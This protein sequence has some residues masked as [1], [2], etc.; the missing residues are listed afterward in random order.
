MNI[1]FLTTILPS[2]R[3]HGSDVASQNIVDALNQNG[4]KV[5]VVGYSRKEDDLVKF[6]PQEILV[7]QRYVETASS[8]LYSLLWLAQSLCQRLPYSSAKYYTKKYIK[9]VNSLLAN[10]NYDIVV[11]DHAQMGWLT[12]FLSDRQKI[13]FV[14]HNIEKDIYI[15]HFQNAK[16]P[17]AKFI[18]QREANLV[19]KMEDSLANKVDE[20]WTLT[21]N[22]AKYFSQ[23]NP[24]LK[25]RVIP[26]P[27]SLDSLSKKSVSKQ[28]DIGLIGS[29]PWKANEQA[30]EWFLENVY[31]HLPKH[32]SIHVAGRGAEWLIGKYPNIEYKDFVPD[33]QE[34]MAQAKVMAIPTLSGGGIEIKTLY[35]IA[36]GSNIVATPTALRGIADPPSTVKVDRDPQRFA[37]LLVNA[38]NSKSEQTA[39]QDVENW[40]YFR[41]EQFCLE[42]ASAIE[43]L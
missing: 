36:S 17:I 10:E 5:S 19:E 30:L 29:W 37:E 27:S 4:S 13:V 7:S 42:I 38:V 33:A 26:L 39:F 8:K 1:L 16:N 24:S 40:Y 34:F 18:Y 14:A 43:E 21:D 3:L 22:D 23:F 25:V 15:Q 31:P 35:S 2:H 9:L 6:S 11:I 32:L 41:Q 20:V 28:F 12:K